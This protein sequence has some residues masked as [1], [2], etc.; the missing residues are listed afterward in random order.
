MAAWRL[1]LQER[2]NLD[3]AEAGLGADA[4][5][6][7]VNEPR[8]VP[9]GV[10]IRRVG[11]HHHEAVRA[12]TTLRDLPGNEGRTVA[13]DQGIVRRVVD[14]FFNG[15]GPV[16]AALGDP[17]GLSKCLGA[18]EI[19]KTTVPGNQAGAE[20]FDGLVALRDVDRDVP[21][22]RGSH[23][24]GGTYRQQNGYHRGVSHTRTRISFPA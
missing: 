1:I 12:L 7:G 10:G 3:R 15:C 19:A 16:V 14:P 2:V 11:V 21:R 5:D 18:I 17:K 24:N 13:R 22:R 8:V 6:T 9:G 4:H 20:T 23:Q